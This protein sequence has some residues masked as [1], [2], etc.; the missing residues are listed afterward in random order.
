MFVRRSILVQDIPHKEQREYLTGLMA[1]LERDKQHS[2]YIDVTYHCRSTSGWTSEPEERW[3][4]QPRY[5]LRD[6]HAHGPLVPDRKVFVAGDGTIGGPLPIRIVK[7]LGITRELPSEYEWN[8]FGF[9]HHVDRRYFHP[10]SAARAF[11]KHR[12]DEWLLEDRP[13][14]LRLRNNNDSPEDNEGDE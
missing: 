10:G 6:P 11:I 2:F 3:I 1:A 4:V 8:M 13:K 14:I 9:V 5:N 7:L 12:G